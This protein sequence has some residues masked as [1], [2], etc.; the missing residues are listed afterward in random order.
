MGNKKSLGNFLVV[1]GHVNVDILLQILE[2]ADEGGFAVTLVVEEVVHFEGEVVGDDS[3]AT[4][5]EHELFEFEGLVS[6]IGGFFN[7]GE[8]L[9]GGV[10]L[11]EERL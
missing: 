6:L 11:L 4:P 10:F 5:L 2:E 3:D 9:V 1:S 8:E 7:D